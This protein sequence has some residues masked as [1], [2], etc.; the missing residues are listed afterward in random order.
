[1]ESLLAFGILKVSFCAVIS[2]AQ[3]KHHFKSYFYQIFKQ[4]TVKKCFELSG[5]LTSK[6]I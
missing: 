4:V 2:L 5:H 3:R 6:G 1:M